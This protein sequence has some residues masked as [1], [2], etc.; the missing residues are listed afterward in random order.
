MSRP[1]RWHM[2]P[3]LLLV[4]VSLAG[5]KGATG[6]AQ[7]GHPT[8]LFV[9]PAF[10]A[11]E[12]MRLP[13]VSYENTS[14]NPDASTYFFQHVE[15][16]LREKPAYTILGTW[17]VDRDVRRKKLK[18][19][20][21]ALQ[22]QWR[23]G[24]TFEP[25]TLREFGTAFGTDL[26]MGIELT[27]WES[28]EIDVNV[29]GYSHSDVAATMKIFDV[30]TGKLLW[31]ATD[32]MELKSPHWDPSSG[33]GRKDELGIV[34]GQSRVVPQAPPVDEAARR[35]AVNLVSSLP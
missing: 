15:D 30:H 14:T 4:L 32:R 5:C 33:G 27:E 13:I 6:G 11:A 9:D 20:H 25:S 29:E 19:Q 22:A 10:V 21:Q 28:V 7:S 24:R 1:Q 2:L 3:I 18:E 16:A 31:E 17:A 12:A 23:E 34:R 8:A 26:V 35:V